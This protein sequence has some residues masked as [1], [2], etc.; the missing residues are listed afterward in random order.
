[1]LTPGMSEMNSIIGTRLVRSR[2]GELLGVEETHTGLVS[3]VCM[4]VEEIVWFV[5]SFMSYILKAK[6]KALVF[7]VKKTKYTFCISYPNSYE[8]SKS[9]ISTP[10][11]K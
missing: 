8:I 7:Q 9:E 5:C 3:E 10:I 11:C 2:A 6:D 1:M 4:R